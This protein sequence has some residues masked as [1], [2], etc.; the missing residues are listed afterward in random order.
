MKKKNQRIY[1]NDKSGLHV[2]CEVEATGYKNR[3]NENK[4]LNKKHKLRF[5]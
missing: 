5:Y 1:I 3:G 2:W 4:L